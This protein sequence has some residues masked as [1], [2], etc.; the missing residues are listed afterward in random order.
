ML[1]AG[2]QL[3]VAAGVFMMMLKLHTGRTSSSLRGNQT[4]LLPSGDCEVV[5]GVSQSQLAEGCCL[6][7]PI[8]TLAERESPKIPLGTF[9]ST[10]YCFQQENKGNRVEVSTN[11]VIE[12]SRSTLSGFCTLRA[13]TW[14][15]ASNED[16]QFGARLS[17]IAL[18][19]SW[20]VLSRATLFLFLF[21]DKTQTKES[22]SEKSYWGS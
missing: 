20:R 12:A 7:R 8:R 3:V 2:R 19:C 17:S 10:L 15:R 1:R 11:E 5:D 4:S 14:V 9:A 18:V 21:C 16:T 6:R 13:G 22:V